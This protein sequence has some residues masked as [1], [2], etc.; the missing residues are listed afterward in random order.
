MNYTSVKMNIF[1]HFM[2]IYKQIPT[3]RMVWND[4]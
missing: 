4:K 1:D 2:K 3:P